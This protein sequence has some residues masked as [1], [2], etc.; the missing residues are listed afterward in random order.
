MCLYHV[1][2][3]ILLIF[4]YYMVATT[5]VVVVV[6]VRFT[7]SY[8]SCILCAKYFRAFY[9]WNFIVA[10]RAM[11][12]PYPFSACWWYFGNIQQ[13]T[14]VVSSVCLY[15]LHPLKRTTT[16]IFRSNS[17]V[18]FWIFILHFDSVAPSY[19]YYCCKFVNIN[20]CKWKWMRMFQ[21]LSLFLGPC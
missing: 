4:T 12:F 11:A 5:T 14:S 16:S 20:K 7:L 21:F 10:V 2:W 15:T 17:W 6:Y 13:Y 18:L 3:A 1:H 9:R 19:A 8:S